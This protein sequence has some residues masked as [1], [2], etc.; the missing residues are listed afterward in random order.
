VSFAVSF[1]PI[2]GPLISCVIDGTFTDMWEAIK[3]GDWGAL[4]LCAMAF[5]PGA[6]VLKGLKAVGGIGDIAKV[7]KKAA[8]SG[9]KNVNKK[10]VV[11]GENMDDRVKPFA[12][13]HGFDYYRQPQGSLSKADSIEH[14]RAWINSRM[15]EGCVIVDIGPDPAR[16]NFPAPTSDWYAMETWELTNRNYLGWIRI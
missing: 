13:K 14:N 9:A 6:K 11:I 7:S 10:V 4:A 1:I 3:R 15:D 16:A 8:K 5:V 12:K 2:V